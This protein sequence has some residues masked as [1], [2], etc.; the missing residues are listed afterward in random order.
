[1]KKS[2]TS[3]FLTLILLGCMSSC[4]TDD[5]DGNLPGGG[6]DT[7]PVEIPDK[8]FGEYMLYEEILG[9]SSEIE[10]NEVKFF[11]DPDEVVT[12]NELSLSKT[13]SNVQQLMDAGLENAEDKI[14]DLTGIEHFIGLQTL[15]LT[16]NDV[17]IIDVSA[18][19]GLE[20]LEINFNL[21]GNLDLSNNT[22]LTRL[23]YR[24]SAQAESNQKLSS[25]DLSN[26]SELRHVFLPNH[27][28]VNID[29]S[30]N[31]QIDELLDLSGN[32]G[33]DGDPD[34]ADIIIP[35]AIYDQLAEG[36][37]LGVVSDADV[38]ATVFLSGEPSLI[39]EDN[40]N[41]TLTVS[42]NLPIDEPVTVDLSFAGT[43]VLDTDYTIDTQQIT[44]PAGELE[45]IATISTVQDTDIEGD[46]SIEVSLGNIV[47]AEAG[48]NQEVNITIEDDDFNVPLILNEIL[49][50]PPG[51]LDGDSNN[52]GT[53][54]SQ[55]DEFI[56]L[57][58]NSDS[59][60][61][62]SGFKIYDTEAL[63][64][65]TPRHIIPDGTIIPPNSAMVIFGGGNPTGSFGGAIVQTASE[66]IL[67]LNNAGD[68]L[69]VQDSNGAVVIT[70][71]IEPLSNN[72]NES[73]T[74][75][76]DITGDFVQHNDDIPEANGVLF[77][78]GTKID[79]STF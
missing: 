48:E 53:R 17:E 69:T 10:N 27:N 58:N 63:E 36:D 52:D 24:G 64:N 23:R 4:S 28:I 39:S 40:G 77:S 59:D 74:R 41:A 19:T 75:N 50:D 25:I 79:G 62:V 22:A 46:E 68:V 38:T 60:L 16:A 32:P 29:L 21:A 5:V 12:V 13:S 7:D 15:V 45:G 66:S 54:D 8:A 33:P 30:N 49:Y 34:T 9:I 57:Y 73:Y 71:D 2:L 42:L 35:A 56:E 20:A 43:A 14:T 70:F 18:L 76:P 11:L 55:D 1:M 6:I 3:Y 47:N 51:G 37:R 26:N 44:I 78:P 67:N 72:P 61:D 31:L 65:D